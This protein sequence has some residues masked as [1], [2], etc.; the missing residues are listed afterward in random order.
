M[1]KLSAR[2]TDNPAFPLKAGI[3]SEFEAA[4]L[5]LNKGT[6]GKKPDGVKHKIKLKN[7]GPG[8]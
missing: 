3:Q 5:T 7:S 6:S 1:Y 2:Y 8:L 4:K